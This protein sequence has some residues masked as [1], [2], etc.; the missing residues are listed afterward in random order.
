MTTQCESVG[1]CMYPVGDNGGIECVS[2]FTEVPPDAQML[3]WSPTEPDEIMRAFVEILK[4]PTAD[5]AHKRQTAGKVSWK[6]D[7]GHRA[8]MY[9][10]LRRWQE[11]ELVDEDSGAP[12]LA[13][14]AWRALALAWQERNA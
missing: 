11:G 4:L 9:R 7:E 5:G 1:H 12:A 8:A 10:H 14:V 6:V 13:H 2:C 3:D